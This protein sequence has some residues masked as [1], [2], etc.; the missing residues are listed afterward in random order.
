M[1]VAAFNALPRDEAV[2]VVAVWAAI[3][4]WVEALVDARPYPDR[5]TLVA[6]ATLGAASWSGAEVEAALADHPRIGERHA[7]SGASAA[8]SARE[9][10]GVDP[11]DADVRARLADGN[12]RYEERFGRVYLVR[13]AGR[14]ASEMVAMLEERLTHDDATERAVTREQLAEIALLRLTSAVTDGTTDRTGEDEA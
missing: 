2:A 11:A 13:A 3:P 12:R 5:A 7:G 9:Q 14:T 8:H 4:S 6:A 1:D 10:A